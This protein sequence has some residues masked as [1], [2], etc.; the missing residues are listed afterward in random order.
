[1]TNPGD[2]FDFKNSKETHRSNFVDSLLSTLLPNLTIKIFFFYFFNQ[3]RQHT[4]PTLS[5]FFPLRC[6]FFF[7]SLTFVIS[8]TLA[9]VLE[10]HSA[11][12]AI[13]G[14]HSYLPVLN[15]DHFSEK[16]ASE[17]TDKGCPCPVLHQTCFEQILP[18]PRTVRQVR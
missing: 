6:V 9:A 2:I 11:S 17:R 4:P 1:M 5:T 8:L 16:A 10:G 12:G 15:P 18:I 14:N 13:H 7:L 3:P